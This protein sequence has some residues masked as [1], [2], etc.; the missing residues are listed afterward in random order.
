[1]IL[2]LENVDCAACGPIVTRALKN[3]EGVKEVMV[4]SESGKA[5]VLFD[6]ASAT[7]DELVEATT[8]SGFPARVS[9]R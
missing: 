6:D 2:D 5:R 3:V 8:N 7:L 1:M 9:R 4:S